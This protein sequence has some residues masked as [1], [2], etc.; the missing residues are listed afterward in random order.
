M[1]VITKRIIPTSAGNLT[2]TVQ[3]IVTLLSWFGKY[4]DAFRDIGLSSVTED[5][6]LSRRFGA[7][8]DPVSA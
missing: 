3:L 2:P 6:R 4:V 5:F 7:H 8:V 1:G